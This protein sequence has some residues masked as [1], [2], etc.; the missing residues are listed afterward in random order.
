[1]NR[2]RGR[3]SHPVRHTMSRPRGRVSHP[4]RH[5]MSRPRGRVGHPVRHTMNRPRGRVSHLVR[6]TMR[7]LVD[8]LTEQQHEESCIQNF[9]GTPIVHGCPMG[10][11][12]LEFEMMTSYAVLCNIP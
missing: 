8:L 3:V 5:T 10:G 6:H 12:N 4:V 9:N 2:P 11:G 7:Q 1:M